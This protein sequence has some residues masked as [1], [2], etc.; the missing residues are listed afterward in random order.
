MSNLH[1]AKCICFLD[2]VPI[3]DNSGSSSNSVATIG[4]TVGAV[5]LLLMIIVVLCIVILYMRRSHRKQDDIS[6][7]NTSVTF[8]NNPSYDS[9]KVNTLDHLYS[10]IKPG[11]SYVPLSSHDA[12][13]NQYDYPYFAD[14]VHILHPKVP[15]NTT[16]SAKEVQVEI[17][18]T[19]CDDR[20]NIQLASSDESDEY[21]VINQPKN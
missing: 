1:V 11:G 12:T 2:N 10:T 4:G 19:N 7:P 8:E 14:N 20:N 18:A 17:Y 15:A 16:D 13:T 21:G 5:V 3:P 9:T 6:K